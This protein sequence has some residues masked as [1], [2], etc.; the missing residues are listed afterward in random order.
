MYIFML[1]FSSCFLRVLH[2]FSNLCFFCLACALS[3]FFPH[4][5]QW[6]FR[7]ICVASFSTHSYLHYIYTMAPHVVYVYKKHTAQ[8]NTH[9]ETQQEQKR[10]ERI[11]KKKQRMR[12]YMYIHVHTY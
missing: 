11:R 2:M 8:K 6:V 1:L 7:Y 4:L 12:V 5:R 10:T 3:L 9:T